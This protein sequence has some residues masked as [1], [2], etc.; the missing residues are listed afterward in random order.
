MARR[1]SIDNFYKKRGGD[2]FEGKSFYKSGR[3]EQERRIA[4]LCHNKRQR[5][6]ILYN[7]AEDRG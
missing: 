7:P 5:I 3:Q 1:S 6:G 2:L 4:K